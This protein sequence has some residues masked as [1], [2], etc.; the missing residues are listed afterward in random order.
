M[1]D[2][3][4]Q[5]NKSIEALRKRVLTEF[6]LA[7][8]LELAPK[9]VDNL[10]RI[11]DSEI[12]AHQLKIDPARPE[13]AREAFLSSITK[14]LDE[15]FT[16]QIVGSKTSVSFKT[17]NIDE[18]LYNV[19]IP[20]HLEDMRG[21]KQP[22][23]LQWLIFYLEGFVGEFAF[24]SLDTLV[25]ASTTPG[26]KRNAQERFGRYGWY[27]QGF[28]V[29]KKEYEET[30]GKVIPFDQVRHPFSGMHPSKLFERALEGVD[31]KMV[32]QKALMRALGK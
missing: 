31:V 23:P 1:V 14:S 8:K 29:P 11:F 27:G 26:R 13:V 12:L 9:I 19:D 25:G 28:M 16:A 32:L 2:F 21:M 18:L 4:A 5:I 30:F 22:H 3:T 17:G 20:E 24:I 10:M 15:T 7:I 6:Q